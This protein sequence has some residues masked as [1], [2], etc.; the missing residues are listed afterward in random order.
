MKYIIHCTCGFATGC[1][2]TDTGMLTCVRCGGGIDTAKKK[3]LDEPKKREIEEVD[4][5]SVE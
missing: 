2:P 5:L 3:P 1:E 4:L